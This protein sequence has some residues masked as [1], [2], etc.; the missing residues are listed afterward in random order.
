[1][2]QVPEYDPDEFEGVGEPEPVGSCERCGCNLYED[3]DEELCDQC[4]WWASQ[5]EQGGSN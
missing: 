4:L 3:D 1:M 5:Y 2:A